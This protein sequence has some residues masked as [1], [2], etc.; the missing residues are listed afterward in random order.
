M[1]HTLKTETQE[2]PL[3]LAP[4]LLY[5]KKKVRNDKDTETFPEVVSGPGEL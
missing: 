3:Q 5:G 2:K 1:E 4:G